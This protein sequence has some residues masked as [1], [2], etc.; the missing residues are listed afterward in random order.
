MTREQLD[1]LAAR[2][3]SATFDEIESRLALDWDEVAIDVRRWELK[4]EAERLSAGLA[5]IDYEKGMVLAK[6]MLPNGEDEE[7]RILARRLMEAKLEALKAEIKAFSGVP[8]RAPF[9]VDSFAIPLSSGATQE[10]PKPAHRIS[11]LAKIYGDQRVAL[12]SWSA[13]TEKQHRGYLALLVNLLDDPEMVD[14]SKEDMR[15]VSSA[16]ISLPANMTK[17]FPGM[18]PR[19]RGP[20]AHLKIRRG[21]YRVACWSLRGVERSVLGAGVVGGSVHQL[22]KSTPRTPPWGCGRLSE[23]LA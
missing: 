10:P 21:D 16:I 6:S 7:L 11:E 2:Y 12:K 15:D 19:Q 9:G 18:S 14:V 1:R 23:G 17:K 3:L 20:M 22:Q 8:W 5:H 4:E 13:R